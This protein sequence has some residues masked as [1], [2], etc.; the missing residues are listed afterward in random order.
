MQQFATSWSCWAAVKEFEL[1]YHTTGIEYM[2]RFSYYSNHK[3]YTL[4][5]N[6]L[7][8]SQVGEVFGQEDRRVGR[9]R[10]FFLHRELGVNL[11]HAETPIPLGTVESLYCSITPKNDTKVT[12]YEYIYIYT[13]IYIYIHICI[14]IYVY[15]HV[16]T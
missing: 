15:T 10:N 1:S 13:H 14:Y 7:T 9:V 3:P 5:S 12:T 2:I 11:G 6:S 8:A 4:N 16:H